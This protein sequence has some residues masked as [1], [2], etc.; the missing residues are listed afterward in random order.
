MNE[1]IKIHDKI[2]YLLSFDY[3]YCDKICEKIKFFISEESG[4]ADS[5]HHNFVF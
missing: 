4:I 5:I 2:R 3:G 1:F